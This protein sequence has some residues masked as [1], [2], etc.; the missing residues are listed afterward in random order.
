MIGGLIADEFNMFR[1]IEE[2]EENKSEEIYD[3][4][5]MRFYC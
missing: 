5:V 2:I 1:K 4:R 3:V